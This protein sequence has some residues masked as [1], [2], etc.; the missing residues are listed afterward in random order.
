MPGIASQFV[1]LERALQRMSASPDAALQSAAQTAQSQLPY[2]YLGA[3]G[4]HLA[5]F[6]PSDAPPP[7]VPSSGGGSP[8]TSL[9]KQ[10]FA[11]TGGDGTDANPGMYKIISTFRQFLDTIV[12]AANSED[13]GTLKAMRDSGKL[14]EVTH[15]A[16]RLKSLVD[17]FTPRV[18][19]IGAAISAG[20]KPGVNVPVGGTV[21]NAVAW[22]TREW[23]FW[24][25]PGRFATALVRRA[26]ASGDPRFVAYS[27][28]YL[29]SFA[30]QVA[31]SP[32]VNSIVGG[33]YRA[34]W[35]RHRWINNYVD[36]W[37]HGAYASKATMAGDVPTPGYAQWPGLCDAK[38]HQKIQLGPLDPMDVMTRLRQ[39]DAFP[40]AL[41]ADFSSYWMTAWHDAYGNGISR[42]SEGALNGAYVMTWLKLWFQTSGDVLGCNPTP[43]L[44]P[45][46]GCD[47][48]QPPW[49]DPFTAPLGDNGAGATP[50]APTFDHD[51]DVAEVVSGVVL[52]L[53]G[54]V[55][56]FFGG[57][58]VGIPAIAG[59]IGMIVD[60]ELQFTWDKLRCDLYWYQHYL[61]N[62]IGVLHN[63]TTLGG[64][65]H[66][67]PAELALD[68]TAMSLLGSP[69]SFASGKRVTRSQLRGGPINATFAKEDYPSKPW[70]GL[71]GTWRNAPTGMSP[72][73]EAPG[74]VGYTASAYPTFLVDDDAANPL[75]AASDVRTGGTWPPGFRVR[76]GEQMPVQFGNAVAN[77]VDL[78]AHAGDDLPDWNLDADRGMAA[79]SW[80][81]KGGQYLDPVQIEP[82]PG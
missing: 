7:D 11:I 75:S 28:G 8:Y 38:L 24:K 31:G 80:Q 10:I 15:M 25:H 17:D 27:I 78:V 33:P 42:F 39:G 77:A 68:V 6:I 5:D 26:R 66:P 51:P 71:L 81:F 16:D 76:P 56:T 37:I 30:G 13:L 62:G 45:P 43:P 34:Q 14:D 47:G 61:H 46:A 19:T 65:T 4:P 58:A 59:G 21:P 40:A 12:P 20:M 1:I 63:L 48:T 35:W 49:V 55:A 69:Y 29:C 23:L 79:L 41:P 36:A 50:P 44:T 52:A 60:G 82:D 70:D 2:A 73:W 22:T 72:G 57:A 53:L 18:L 64:F 9:W 67:Y 32:F 54:I 74:T 3:I